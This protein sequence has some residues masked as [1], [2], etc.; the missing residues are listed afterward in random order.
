M[1]PKDNSPDSQRLSAATD[2]CVKVRISSRVDRFA[3]RHR[4]AGNIRCESRQVAAN[5]CSHRRETFSHNDFSEFAGIEAVAGRRNDEVGD[6][7]K[8]SIADDEYEIFLNGI[9]LLNKVSVFVVH[10]HQGVGDR[11]DLLSIPHASVQA[12]KSIAGPSPYLLIAN[13]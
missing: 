10:E 8:L 13:F 1:E 5:E 2:R 3:G 12:S 11:H 4:N 9:G 7:S 6:L